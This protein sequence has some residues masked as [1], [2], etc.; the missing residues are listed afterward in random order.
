[1]ENLSKKV[2][3]L[4]ALLSGQRLQSISLIRLENI[5]EYSDGIRI[6]ITD[7]TK[8]NKKNNPE[9]L[10]DFPFFFDYP[11][12]CIASAVLCYIERTIN[13]QNVSNNNDFIFLTYK[14]PIHIASKQTLSRWVKNMLHDNGVDTTI[15]SSHS[16][17]HASTS[18]SNKNLDFIHLKNPVLLQNFII[19]LLL[20][21]SL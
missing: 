14:K 11:E 19:N 1:M 10:L 13:F 12:I 18:L 5:I 17:R 6:K 7:R 21:M 3:T 16:T 2:V 4:L 15:F 9:P 20:I 8:T